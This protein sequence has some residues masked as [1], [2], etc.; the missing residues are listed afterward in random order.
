MHRGVETAGVIHAERVAPQAVDVWLARY[1]GIWFWVWVAMAVSISS[2]LRCV[3]DVKTRES[4][5]LLHGTLP[6][7]C[8]TQQRQSASLSECWGVG[9]REAIGV[10]IMKQDV[11]QPCSW[12]RIDSKMSYRTLSA[13]SLGGERYLGSACRLT[14]D[15]FWR[16]RFC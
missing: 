3:P 13:S 12:L 11:Q 15:C 7:C 4:V 5:V 16:T 9:L 14:G 10:E 8:L 6:S 1:A 2:C